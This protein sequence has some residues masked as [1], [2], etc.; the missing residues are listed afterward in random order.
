MNFVID[1]YL[2][3]CIEYMEL[4]GSHVRRWGILPQS[5]EVEYYDHEQVYVVA[6]EHLLFTKFCQAGHYAYQT[7]F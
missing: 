3:W 4:S 5:V 6:N 2:S 7:Y 1:Y